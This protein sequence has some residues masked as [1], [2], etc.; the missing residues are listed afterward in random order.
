MDTRVKN[1]HPSQKWMPESKMDAWVKNRCPSWR[2]TPK[3]KIDALDEVWSP[4]AKSRIPTGPASN[5]SS[6]QVAKKLGVIF[7]KD[8]SYW[9]FIF[10][11]YLIRQSPFS[12]GR[13]CLKIKPYSYLIATMILQRPKNMGKFRLSKL[14][15]TSCSR[16]PE[17]LPKNLFYFKLALYPVFDRE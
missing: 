14:D 2:W 17:T 5:Q 3:S 16:K 1:G 11:M 6:P 4:R 9:R 10:R 13:I 8:R 7:P 12:P 15:Y